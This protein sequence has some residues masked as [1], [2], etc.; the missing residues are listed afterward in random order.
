[1]SDTFLNQS[2]LASRW[3]LSPRTL[4][5]RLVIPAGGWTVLDLAGTLP[6]D[7][8][9]AVVITTIEGAAVASVV[10]ESLE[11]PLE[12]TAILARPFP[13]AVGGHSV[14]VRPDRGLLH[15]LVEPTVAP[16]VLAPADELP[17]ST[18]GVTPAADPTEPSPEP[19]SAPATDAPSDG[20][21]ESG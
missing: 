8:G 18:P 2:R 21:T 6:I 4:A 10:S 16:D 3:H 9:F 14:V 1:M 17:T 19:S 7:G 12:L 15:P 20:A 11:G 13:G 5:D